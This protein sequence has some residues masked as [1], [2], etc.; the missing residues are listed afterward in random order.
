MHPMTAACTSQ[1]QRRMDGWNSEKLHASAC[2]EMH[3]LMD[4]RID[5]PNRCEFDVEFELADGPQNF[6][7]IDK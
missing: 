3:Y 4:G 2:T 6:I 7:V 5:E 1:C